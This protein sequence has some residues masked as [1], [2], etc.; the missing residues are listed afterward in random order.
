MC[1]NWQIMTL[2]FP[3][4][5]VWEMWVRGLF[6]NLEMT[7]LKLSS[8]FF[9]FSNFGLIFVH[10]NLGTHFNSYNLLCCT[11][12]V[13][14]NDYIFM[15]IKLPFYFLIYCT[16]FLPYKIGIIDNENHN[17]KARENTQREEKFSKI[18]VPLLFIVHILLL[19][20]LCALSILDHSLVTL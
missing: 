2:W 18:L 3:V 5:C 20:F 19:Y 10:T 4:V 14:W 15:S 13:S 8:N 12:V 16:R 6:F 9:F 11:M 7:F 1:I 17:N